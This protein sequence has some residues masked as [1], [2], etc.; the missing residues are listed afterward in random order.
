[1]KYSFNNVSIIF[2]MGVMGWLF[3]GAVKNLGSAS[4]LQNFFQ[5]MK[6]IILIGNLILD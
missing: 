3:A 6:V 5:K 2:Q 4:H 1:M